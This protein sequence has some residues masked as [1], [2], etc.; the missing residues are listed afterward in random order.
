MQTGTLYI[1]ATPIGNR[2]DITYRAVEV[3][4]MVDLIA[5]E[6]TRETQ[7]IL[8]MYTLSTPTIS[9]HAQSAPSREDELL[10]HLAEGKNLALVSD[11]GTP[12][13]SD[14]GSRLIRRAI[15]AGCTVV[16]IPGAS[17]LITGL[18]AS[19]ADTT[20]FTFL[21]FIPHKKGRQTFLHNALERTET[22]VWYESPH[23]IIKC[24]QQ[25]IESGVNERYCIVARELTKQYEEFLRGTTAEILQQLTQRESIKGEFVVI[26]DRVTGHS[27]TLP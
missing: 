4:G 10:Q 12:G 3:L 14:P 11:R 19:G 5:C 13:I 25:L 22:V 23:R 16:P 8:E 9:Y 7:K 17:A 2:T 20:A 15:E 18:Q 21:G 26:L 1:V 27:S 6:D 24:L